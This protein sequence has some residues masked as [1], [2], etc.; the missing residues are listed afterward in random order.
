MILILTIGSVCAVDTNQTMQMEE[1]DDSSTVSKSYADLES[2]ISESGDI[3]DFKDDYTFNLESDFDYVYG[4]AIERNL[5]I[6]GNNH[7]IN[8]MDLAAAFGINNVSHVKINDLTIQCCVI[9]AIDVTNSNVFLNNVKFI[10]E[11]NTTNT[12][13]VDVYASY[14]NITIN[15]SLFSGKKNSETSSILSE[16]PSNITIENTIFMN[17]HS[18]YGGA[19]SIFDTSLSIKNST[20]KNVHA[21][22]TGGAIAA[23]MD[24]KQ[25]HYLLIEDCEFDNITCAKNGGAIFYDAIGVTFNETVVRTVSI[26]N[27]TFKNCESEFG[28]AVLQLNGNLTIADSDFINN[29]AKRYGGAVYTSMTNL[30]ITDSQFT[31]NSAETQA[32]ALYFDN[33]KL[34][35]SDSI[36]SENKVDL[37]GDGI[38]NGIYMYDTDA[39]IRSSRFSNGGISIYG[40]YTKRATFTNNTYDAV[41]LNN[42][43]DVIAISNNGITLNLTNNSINADELPSKFD[44]RDWGWVTPVK[45]QGKKG[46]CWVFSNV[47]AIESAL[48]KATGM[49]FDISENNV[50]GNR[51]IYAI[52]GD[53]RC[54]EG[55]YNPTALGYALSWIGIIP[56]DEDV[57]DELSKASAIQDSDNRIHIQDAIIIMHG[58]LDE[59]IRQMKEALMKYGALSAGLHQSSE[60]PVYNEATYA[61]YN[62][63]TEHEDHLITI[64]GWDDTFS[65]DNFINT[66]PGDGAWIIKNSWGT[67]WGDEGYFYMSY[68]DK[69]FG[70]MD[71]DDEMSCVNGYIFENTI[72]YTTNYQTDLTGLTSFNGNYSHYSNTFISLKDDMI[73]AVGTYF[74]ESGIDYEL[75]L[76]VN[77]ELRHV[78]SGVSEYGGFKTIILDKYIP[79]KANDV[80]RV[81]FKSNAVPS[82]YLSRQHVKNERSYVSRDGESWIDYASLNKTVCLKVY[83]LKDDAKIICDDEITVEYGSDSYFIVKI[84]TGD[85]RPVGAGETVYFT[86]DGVTTSALS[87]NDGIAKIRITNKPGTYI[88]KT[89]L[90]GETYTT[91]LIVKE[92]VSPEPSERITPIQPRKTVKKNVN[93]SREDTRFVAQNKVISQKEFSKGYKYKV[94]LK[95]KSGK[96]LANKKVILILNGITLIGYTDE[97]GTVYFNLT[98]NFTG[99]FNIT[100]IFEGDEY[101]NPR[102]ETRTIE[103]R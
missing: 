46:S 81:E 54:F 98:G 91:R 4:I 3:F 43:D 45:N 39:D 100:L 79:I 56:E 82:Q 23:K 75:K 24:G 93:P 15:N 67:E 77:D 87:D 2:D 102:T 71:E 30:K 61:L 21:E 18:N 70:V 40:T 68:Y 6:N 101:Y 92:E 72:P 10:G 22:K 44:L 89:E 1:Q 55:G 85:G 88:I 13:L 103:I 80:F 28:G 12:Y 58:E 48:L 19:I 96:P 53:L 97:N 62:N 76:Y 16:E 60:A 17:L 49:E 74:N 27:S 95:S 9:K 8:G 73:G 32:G 90:N 52:Y 14:S 37:S 26:L 29:S 25:D 63:E 33:A 57:Y 11:V 31:G 20:F 5:T 66:P 94:I 51:L 34:E 84:V 36:F 59:T 42:S 78:Q 86:I 65:K 50:H 35:I 99:I 69:S 38:G 64:V 7:T 41:L 83:T 47:A